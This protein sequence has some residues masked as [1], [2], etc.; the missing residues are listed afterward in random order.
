MGTCGQPLEQGQLSP[1]CCKGTLTATYASVSPFVRG[2]SNT[3]LSLGVFLRP[4]GVQSVASLL[5]TE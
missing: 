4:P 5:V 1:W 3:C 2:T